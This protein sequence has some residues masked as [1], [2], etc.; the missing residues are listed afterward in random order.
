MNLAPICL[1]TYKRLDCTIQTI[2]ALQKNS[3]ASQSVLYIFSDGPKKA[4]DLAEIQKVRDFTDKIQGFKEVIHFHKENNSGLAN[5]IIAGVSQVIAEH[6]KVIVLEDDLITTPNFLAFMNQ[7][8]DFYQHKSEVFSIAGYTIPIKIPNT[9]PFDMYACPRHNPWGWA[10]WQDRWETVDWEVKGYTKFQN[11]VEARARFNRGGSDL[12]TMLDKQMSE[13]LD[14]WAIRWGFQQ[15]QNRQISIHPTV[16]KVRNIGF[17]PEATHTKF[18]D[19]YRSE[20]DQTQKQD[21]N[22]VP[23]LEVPDFV[24]KTYQDKYSLRKRF[25]GRLKHYLGLP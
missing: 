19:R 4:E 16:S 9:Y 7:S 22:F 15:F 14:S 13:K 1:F 18:Y 10:S 6:Q 20:L 2:E 3:L 24:L 21:F 5:S 17:G 8:L 12:A 25:I 23:I 11:D